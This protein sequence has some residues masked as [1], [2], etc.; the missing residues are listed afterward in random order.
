MRHCRFKTTPHSQ[1]AKTLTKYTADF[2][3]RAAR[4]AT[5][6]S[7][8]LVLC[9]VVLVQAV[10]MALPPDFLSGLDWAGLVALS[11]ITRTPEQIPMFE[12]PA[13]CP[14]M[15]PRGSRAEKALFDLTERDRTTPEWHSEGNG[16]RLAAAVKDLDY[17]G[18]EPISTPIHHIGSRRPIARYSLSQKAKQAAYTMRHG[19]DHA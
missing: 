16:W 19:S 2:I 4:L 15:P 17:L 6:D 13:F 14:L 3:A 5:A 12:G 9:V 18:W 11:G 7:G 10:L 8:Y 1:P